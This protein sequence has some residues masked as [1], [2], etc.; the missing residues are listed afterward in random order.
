MVLIVD[1]EKLSYFADDISVLSA[2]ELKLKVP[3]KV[4][5]SSFEVLQC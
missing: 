5:L 2:K 4:Y 3:I 1:I